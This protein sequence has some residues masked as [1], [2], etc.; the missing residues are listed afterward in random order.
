MNRDCFFFRAAARRLALLAPPYV[1]WSAKTLRHVHLP[2]VV[3]PAC[4]PAFASGC[5]LREWRV[6]SVLWVWYGAVWCGLWLPG[7]F[8]FYPEQFRGEC[9]GQ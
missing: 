5:R 6:E 3:A 2:C 9:P 1:F 4:L 8:S 7:Q